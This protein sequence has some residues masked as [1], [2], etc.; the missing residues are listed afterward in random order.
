MKIVWLAIASIF[1][2]AI[3]VSQSVDPNLVF[4]KSILFLKAV[5]SAEDTFLNNAIAFA[6]G[7][8]APIVS[9]LMN[10]FTKSKD[11]NKM[12]AQ[13]Q[14]L[15]ESFQALSRQVSDISKQ[16]DLSTT[17]ITTEDSFKE[18]LRHITQIETAS[19]RLKIIITSHVSDKDGLIREIDQEI[20][21]FRNLPDDLI[22]TLFITEPNKYLRMRSIAENVVKLNSNERVTANQVVYEFYIYVMRCVARGATFLLNCYKIKK[23][24]SPESIKY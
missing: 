4:D 18:I 2:G 12:A 7:P 23:E 13:S 8:A 24:L 17:R 20:A 15:N 11:A 16:I 14:F 10:M 21:Q 19:S 6:T 5:S 3:Q 22:T 9:L 1:L